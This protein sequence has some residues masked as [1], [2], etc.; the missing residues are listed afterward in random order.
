M[1]ENYTPLDMPPL[2]G[3]TAAVA[4]A[5][6]ALDDVRRRTKYVLA[7]LPVPAV[8]WRSVEGGHSIGT[9]L[10][11]I[12]ATE[13]EWICVDVLGLSGFAD[14]IA[15]WLAAGVRDGHGRLIDVSG[16]TLARHVERLDATR[17]FTCGILA[18]MTPE[19]F[20]RVRPGSAHAITAEW[21]VHHLTQHEAEHRG[22]IASLK[23]AA[24]L[25]L[26]HA[27]G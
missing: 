25:A 4:R 21:V 16:E 6:W 27:A 2:S 3:P 23:R 8:D 20:R 24:Q 1:T 12:A 9:L 17:S 22:Q 7:G 11:H 26:R 10:Y 18:G 5:L 14:E 15:P 13:M 19:E